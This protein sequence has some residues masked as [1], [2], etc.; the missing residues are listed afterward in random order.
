MNI[1][2]KKSLKN[3]REDLKGRLTEV[4]QEFE[5]R[6]YFRQMDFEQS[7]EDDEDN[8]FDGFE[9]PLTSDDDE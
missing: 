6:E 2:D 3:V 1:R 4:C 7:Q 9:Y 5:T 8:G